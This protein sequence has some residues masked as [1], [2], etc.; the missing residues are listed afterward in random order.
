MEAFVRESGIEQIEESLRRIRL[1]NTG[2][3]NADDVVLAKKHEL[4]YFSYSPLF[5]SLAACRRKDGRG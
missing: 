1:K 3:T 5:S 2:G 4:Q